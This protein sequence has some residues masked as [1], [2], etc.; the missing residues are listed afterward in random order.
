VRDGVAMDQA[1]YAM[2]QDDWRALRSSA[3]LPSSIRVH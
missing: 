1:L 2:L 3:P